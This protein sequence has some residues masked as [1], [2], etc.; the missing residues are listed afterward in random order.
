MRIQLLRALELK[1]GCVGALSVEC[2]ALSV[3]C[4]AGSIELRVRRVS[5]RRV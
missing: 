1:I 5:R 2:R 4:R 3:E